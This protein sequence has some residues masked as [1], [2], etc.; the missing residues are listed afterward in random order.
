ML[1]QFASF[2]VMFANES[3]TSEHLVHV[4][5]LVDLSCG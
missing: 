2:W 1:A 3:Q 4:I 5:V